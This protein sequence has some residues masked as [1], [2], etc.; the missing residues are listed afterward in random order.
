VIFGTGLPGLHAGAE[1]LM[2]AAPDSLDVV[3]R[4]LGW[5]DV[6]RSLPTRAKRRDAENDRRIGMRVATALAAALGAGAVP[7]GDRRPSR[8]VGPPA[9]PSRA[10]YK[11]NHPGPLQPWGHK[12]VGNAYVPKAPGGGEFRTLTVGV[13]LTVAPGTDARDARRNGGRGDGRH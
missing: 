10:I 2:V 3:C 4:A 8:A 11:R 12:H 6:G 7:V 9:L 1:D 5:P 13:R